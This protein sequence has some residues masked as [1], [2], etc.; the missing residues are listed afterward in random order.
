MPK[1]S[2]AFEGHFHQDDPRWITTAAGG[3]TWPTIPA[4]RYELQA[5]NATL[6]W[7]P[8]RIFG[9]L[10]QRT[11]PPNVHDDCTWGLLSS[12]APITWSWISRSW[13]KET[14]LITW[15]IELMSIWCYFPAIF[16][17]TEEPGKC[18]GEVALGDLSCTGALGSSGEG[19]K[20]VPVQFDK[21][22]PEE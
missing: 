11:S 16:D 2:N 20:L 8:L 5:P 22:S 18:N 14:E 7:I 10:Y 19:T 21:S 12:I 1:E 13:D 3:C 6:H 9:A 17:F 4:H 15:H